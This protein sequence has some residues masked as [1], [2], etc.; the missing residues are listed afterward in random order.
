MMGRI[1][2][3]KLKQ[4]YLHSR[5]EWKRKAVIYHFVDT[6]QVYLKNNK[7][8]FSIKVISQRKYQYEQPLKIVS[9][10]TAVFQ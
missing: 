10:M 7:R 3:S 2:I 6:Q 4:M 1:K 9:Y 8:L 5:I